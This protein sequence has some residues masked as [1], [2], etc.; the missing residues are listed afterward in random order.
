MCV[1]GGVCGWEYQESRWL[2]QR[3][4]YESPT[5]NR[6]EI[7]HSQQKKWQILD[8]RGQWIWYKTKHH[9]SD[10]IISSGNISSTDETI[11]SDWKISDLITLLKT[12]L[13]IEWKR[14]QKTMR[15]WKNGGFIYYLFFFLIFIF[16]LQ[17]IHSYN[18]PLITFAEALLH[19]FIAAGSV[20]GTS[21]GCRAEIRTRACLTASQ[22][23]TN[24]AALHPIG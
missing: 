12:I 24:W 2:G 3:G 5:K 20:G 17:T 10:N 18:H 23:T 22:R 16:Q 19:I 14:Q 4:T 15:S 1:G 8:Q 21:L 11:P 9:V 13:S 6:T 7:I